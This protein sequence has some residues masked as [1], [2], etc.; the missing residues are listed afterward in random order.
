VRVAPVVGVSPGVAAGRAGVAWLVGVP[1]VPGV[2]GVPRVRTAVDDPLLHAASKTAT[3]EV[4]Q[5]RSSVRRDRVA[6]AHRA[7]C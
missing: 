1:G 2:A 4:V 5:A 7:P 3:A 6:A